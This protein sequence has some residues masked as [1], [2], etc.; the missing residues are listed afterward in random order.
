MRTGQV[1]VITG[2]SSGIGRASALRFAEQGARLALAS[3]RGQVLEELAEECR[4]RGGDAI[5]VPTDTTD[6]EAVRGLAQAAVARF[7][8]IDVWVNDAAVS[9][10]APLVEVPLDE[11]RRVIDVDVMGYVHGARAAL[12]VMIPQRR[13]VIVNVS[14]IV[15]EV[16]QPYTAAYGMSKAAVRALGVSMRA[17]L[18]LQKLKDVH[19]ATVLPP[20]VD[21]P[22]FRHSANHTGRMVQAMPPVYSV[23]RVA[24]V[25]VRTAQA[26]KDE[27]VIGRLGRAMVRQHRLSP[28]PVEAQMA[29]MVEKTHLSPTK[30]A[31]PTKGILFTPAQDPEDATATGGW[32]GRSRTAGRVAIAGALA[33]HSRRS[34]SASRRPGWPRARPE[35]AW[36]QGRVSP[37]SRLRVPR[38]S[39]VVS[40]STSSRVAG[41]SRLGGSP[42]ESISR[43]STTIV[44]RSHIPSRTE[45]A[46]CAESTTF[47]PERIG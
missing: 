6:W 45:P 16:P 20:T 7:G 18:A 38:S 12:E 31:A 19:V 39:A 25:I 37:S 22:F 36:S 42:R 14:S 27:V 32:A 23:D 4:S 2:A 28:R 8:R 44:R 35:A 30:P 13:G 10:F 46:R 24:A 15:G 34:A 26:P 43:S 21:T 29:A 9:V 5:A 41:C 17:E 3:R 33:A 11:F 47:S 1:V 40:H